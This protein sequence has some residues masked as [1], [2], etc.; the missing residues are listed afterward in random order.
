[1]LALLPDAS[2][3]SA[4]RTQAQDG[5]VGALL[6]LGAAALALPL[7]L[8]L[9]LMLLAGHTQDKEARRASEAQAASA[10]RVALKRLGQTTLDYAYWDDA[11]QNLVV[12]FDPVWFDKNLGAYL[13][14]TFDVSG[15][16]V[17]DGAGREAAVA[18]G[19]DA[20]PQ[21]L[22]A[23]QGGL[24]EMLAEARAFE[25]EKPV[26]SIGLVSLD[27]RLH[28]AAAS[29]IVPFE[30]LVG[31][32]APPR[33][34]VLVLLIELNEEW[35][36]E[37][38]E[39]TTLR[40]LSLVG[41]SQA[42]GGADRGALSLTAFD[43]SALGALAWL[44]E[45]PGARFQSLVVVPVAIAVLAMAVLAG[46]TARRILGT[47]RALRRALE[48]SRAAAHAKTMFLASMSHELRTPLNA[49]IGFSEIMEQE[50]F[51][52][53]GHA[54]Y[55]Q[56][57]SD[58]LLSGRHLLALIDG[59]LEF[60]RIDG[61]AVVLAPHRVALAAIAREALT[62]LGPK[63]SAKGV[64]VVV[65]SATELPHAIAD[66]R[67]MRQVL[68][69]L[70]DNAVKW[71]PRGG[72]VEVALRCSPRRGFEVEVSDTGPGVAHDEQQRI[73]QPFTQAEGAHARGKG[74]AG[75]GLAIVRTLV[76]LHGGEVGLRSTAAGATF[77]VTLPPECIAPPELTQAA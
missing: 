62:L 74:G 5:R 50:M 15:V 36:A 7:A 46:L 32:D 17:F 43:G 37:L 28:L 64:T 56:Y 65:Q 61:G 70:I 1:M 4:W 26:V 55:R 52:P 9:A 23:S 21:P 75:L 29:A 72:T 54:S 30:P 68:L 31:R 44:Q 27:G 12:A 10:L 3:R 11:V 57:A 49:V 25:G 60:S 18:F 69:N 53:I 34:W 59:V 35:I 41:S 77:T 2:T 67:A 40:G 42:E 45:R 63:T 19:E 6:A 76:R 58:I 16:A 33:D 73:W 66:E 20:G 71:T 8:A 38:E 48:E 39:N 13:R 51:G 22:R 24:A 47:A 14:D